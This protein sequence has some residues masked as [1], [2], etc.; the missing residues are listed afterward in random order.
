[1]EANHTQDIEDRDRLHEQ[2]MMAARL[3]LDRA[4]EISRQK[5]A[6]FTMKLSELESDGNAKIQLIK[7]LQREVDRLERGINDVASELEQKG[8]EILRIRSEMLQSSK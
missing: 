7:E 6:E 3:E 5:E 2:Q 8:Q 1:M 4:L